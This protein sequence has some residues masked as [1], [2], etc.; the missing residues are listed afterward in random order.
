MNILKPKN[1]FNPV[2]LHKPRTMSS[3]LPA[4][5]RQSLDFVDETKPNKLSGSLPHEE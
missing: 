3:A 5:F 2:N 4:E 1:V